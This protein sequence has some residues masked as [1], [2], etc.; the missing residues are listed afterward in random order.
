MEVFAMLTITHDA[1]DLLVHMRRVADAPDTFGARLFAATPPGG[2]GG[3][4]IAVAFVPEAEP[5][6]KVTEQEGLTAYVAADVVDV[7]DEA[8]LDASPADGGEELV[9]RR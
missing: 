5:G 9:I 2:G 4:S 8:T 7:L 1:A 3:P 6:D